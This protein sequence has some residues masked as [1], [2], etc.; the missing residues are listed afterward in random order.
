M[1]NK[2]LIISAVV[3]A[4]LAGG[5]WFL[6][7]NQAHPLP[8]AEGDTI[9]SWDWQGTHEDGGELE[10]R[11]N[12]EIA[13][14]KSLL[15]GDQSGKNDDPTDY[16]LYVSIANQYELLGDGKAAYDNLGRALKID[17][18]KTGLAWRNLGS[19]MERLGA[20]QTARIAYARAVEAQPGEEYHIARLSFL[21]KHFADDAATLEAA[22]EEAEKDLGETPQILQ[23]KA[24]WYEKTG[25]VDD[26]I[27]A[28]QGMEKLMGGND[29]SARSE[30]ARLRNL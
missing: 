28:L 2:N 23:L 3:V 22:F 11:A 18:T 21:I 25:R 24:Q 1:Q 12:D 6:L 13:R 8:L 26:A 15:G 4:L 19:L 17:S 30:M 9:A 10:K 29:G 20:L 14:S 7:Q 16:I 27:E 5:A